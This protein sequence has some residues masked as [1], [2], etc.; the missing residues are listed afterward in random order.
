[1]ASEREDAVVA[2]LLAAGRGTRM[3]SPLPKPLV[4]LAGRPLVA[5]L[6]DA[7]QAAGIARIVAVVGHGA[8]QVSAALPASVSTAL[9]TVRDGT[10]SAVECAETI[11]RDA[12]EVLVFVG[13]AP[14]VSPES[15][16]RLVAHRR[17]TEAAVAFLTA[18]FPIP[19]PYARVVRDA[20]GRCVDCVEERDCT[21]AQAAIR[22][23]MTSH[24]VFDATRL[25]PVLATVR[26]HP[27]TR[28]RYL[29]DVLTTLHRRGERVETVR[30]ETWQELVGLNT[31]AE[32]AWA[33]TVWAARHG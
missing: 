12:A 21:P 6:I 23:Y 30:A 7:V 5:H 22:E 33:E 31:P 14:M 1:M 19:L 25:W 16:R 29:T 18:E 9:Q 3:G 10:A 24:Y 4:P 17:Q 13:D 2:V 15:I 26:P 27:V 32:L 28:E 11:C 20:H 8:D